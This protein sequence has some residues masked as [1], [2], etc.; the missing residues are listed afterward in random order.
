M[1]LQRCL[2]RF[3]TADCG[4]SQLLATKAEL[5]RNEFLQDYFRLF[6]VGPMMWAKVAG[7][8]DYH[9]SISIVRP[10][11]APLFDEAELELLTVLAP[12]LRKAL[13]LSRM[14]HNLRSSN[15][16]LSQSLDEMEIAI[17]MV[18]QD[19]SVVRSTEGA[20]QLFASRNGVWLD[21]GRFRTEVHREQRALELMVHE[22][23]QTG[24]NGG[25]NRPVRVQSEAA[26][27]ATVRS[28]SPRAGG[29]L[30]LSRKPPLPSLQVVV[31]PFRSGPLLL[32]PRASAIIQFSDPSAVPRSR[33]AILRA[34]YALTPA[35]SRLADLLLQG[36]EV[37]EASDRMTITIETARIH[38]KRVLAKT[39]AHRQTQ[40]M[41]LM[42]S[43]PA[44]PTAPR[45]D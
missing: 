27:N 45:W 7:R 28:W 37:R 17:C 43:L 11:L 40:L 8:P 26:G 38:L 13:K 18:K 31:S 16:L 25:V 34:L 4:V 44:E 15:A 2:E 3:R 33:G 5:Q 32:E 21:G 12:H 41:R 24:E 14:F 35:E 9:A 42:L 19:G 1:Y 10:N 36:L 23:C 22:A 30:L 6:D 29:A 39:G 20:V